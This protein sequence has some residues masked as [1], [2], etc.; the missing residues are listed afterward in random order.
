VTIVIEIRRAAGRFV[1]QTDWLESYHSFSF[2]GHYNHHNVSHGLLVV[3]ND[4][5][6]MPG[7]GFA[8][9]THA[10]MEIVTWVISG[11]LEHRDSQG[12]H[13]ILYPGLAQRMSTGTGIEHSE[14]NP[15]PDEAVRFIQMWVTPDTQ[16]VPPSYEQLDVNSYLHQGVLVPV[17]SGRGGDGCITLRQR[18][19]ALWVARLQGDETL[20]LPD[21]A[22]GHLF[23]CSGSVQIASGN[24]L[25][26]GDAA[27][28][29]GASQFSIMALEPTEILYWEMHSSSKR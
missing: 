17:A 10:D 16:G 3:N 12:N 28:L 18:D 6:V 23:V 4:D 21:C 19:A 2:N 5:I 7:T 27:R 15:N 1:T 26:H 9:H 29:T 11:R 8:T 24:T 13:G 20:V 22:F 14:H 25:L